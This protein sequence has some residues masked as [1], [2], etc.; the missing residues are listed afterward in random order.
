MARGRAAAPEPE[1]VP[2]ST[3]PDL[4]AAKI[5]AD[6][7]TTRI[8][9]ARD[10]YYGRDTLIVDDAEYD[11]WMHRLEQLERFFPEL[12][13][14]DSPTQTVGAARNTLFTPVR[15]AEPMLS[16]DNVFSRDEFLAWGRRWSVTR[17]VA[18]ITCASSR[19]TAS[20]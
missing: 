5:Q 8:L 2:E 11:G 4:A 7:L 13:S 3:P 14:Q 18:S 16:L 17:V 12:Q 1:Q 15:H 10:A 6:E 9:E 19:S 20:P